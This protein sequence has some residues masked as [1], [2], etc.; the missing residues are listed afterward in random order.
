MPKH[1]TEESESSTVWPATQTTVHLFFNLS[2][3]LQTAIRP[4]HQLYLISA[5]LRLFKLA[6][7]S[8]TQVTSPSFSST[9]SEDR[10]EDVIPAH[11]FES[12]PAD[13]E[14]IRISV[15]NYT[16]GAKRHK[17]KYYYL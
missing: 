9:P 11:L 7:S 5:K 3:V 6:E 12:S 2:S 16:R 14:K 4:G 13:D 1:W 15:H 8:E 10:I 17:G